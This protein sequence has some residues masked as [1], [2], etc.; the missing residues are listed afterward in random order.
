MG[1]GRGHTCG[2]GLDLDLKALISEAANYHDKG[3]K[4]NDAIDAVFDYMLERLNNYYHDQNISADVRDAVLS[5]K[6]CRPLD[7]HN[8]VYAVTEFR[9]LDAAES[10]AAANKRI[11]NILKK[12]EGKIADK[13]DKTLLQDDAEKVLNDKLDTLQDTVQT[14]INETRYQ[15]ALNQLA[16][17][18]EPVDKFFDDVMVMTDDEALKNNRIA[19]LNQ[20]HS[21]FMQVADISRLQG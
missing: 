20:L 11:G 3:I 4:A 12:V 10:L 15:D 1:K 2:Q 8:R 19:L 9:K 5:L 17:L 16:D 18:R 6:P 7:I 21:L 13:V 14:A